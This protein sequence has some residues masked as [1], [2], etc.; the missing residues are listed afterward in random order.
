[1]GLKVPYQAAVLALSNERDRWLIARLA[2]AMDAHRRGFAEGWE[3][4]RRTLLGEL[5]EDERYMLTGLRPVFARPDHAELEARRWG[6]G[7]REHFGDPAP[8][9]YSGGPVA[10]W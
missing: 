2:A 1:M 8:G 7:G 3:A 10:A 9:G 5:A 4:G 6:P